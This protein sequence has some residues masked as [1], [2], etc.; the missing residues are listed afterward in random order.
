MS[1]PSA[2]LILLY[3]SLL[4]FVVSLYEITHHPADNATIRSLC[5][6]A[7]GR[8]RPLASLPSPPTCDMCSVYVSPQFILSDPKPCNWSDQCPLCRQ[9]SA[10]GEAMCPI[11]GLLDE[12]Q[13]VGV[14]FRGWCHA[15]TYKYYIERA[16]F[17]SMMLNASECADVE[18]TS[19]F[20]L[21]LD[22]DVAK[23]FCEDLPE[24]ELL[25]GPFYTQEP[26]L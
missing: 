5:F 9:L 15:E 20:M 18:V 23:V 17:V 26:V 1:I 8:C 19:P 10:D 7:G 16:D 12:R 2:L 24:G 4:P 21:A 3:C 6:H 25:P 13:A 11:C 22:N 14:Q